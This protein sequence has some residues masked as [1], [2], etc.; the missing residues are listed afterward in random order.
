MTDGMPKRGAE[1][2]VNT[3][4]DSDA[5]IIGG[6]CAGLS[7]AR[8]AQ[9]LPHQRVAIIEGKAKR[10][11]HAWGVFASDSLKEIAADAL[12]M[13]RKTWHRWQII[14]AEGTATQTSQTRP[15]ACLE[16]KAWLTYCRQQARENGVRFIHDQVISADAHSI[17]T[18]TET[19]TTDQVYDSRPN[20]IPQG[21]MIQHFIGHEIQVVSP[22]FDPD[23]AILMDFR[24]DQSRGIHFIYVLPFSATQ[25][26]VES[27]VFS[28]QIEDN[29]FY[30][31]AIAAYLKDQFNITE[32]IVLRREQGAIPMGIIPEDH[33]TG[34][35]IGGRG[36]AIRPS[37][38][39]AF[40]FIQRQLTSLIDNLATGN[41]PTR[42]TPHHK[43]DLLMD[44]IFLKV[45]HRKPKL[46]PRLF[47]AIAQK[48]TGDEMA[49]FMA[50][51][52]DLALR[53]KVIMAMPKWPFI[54]AL[55]SGID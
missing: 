11:D 22:V 13:T 15:Y 44:R 14:T 20:P 30:E 19:I 16:S 49:R 40:A 55:I 37:S 24:C 42:M 35:P 5:V 46:A 51:E 9:S 6:G 25:A 43:I 26:L 52:A 2:P 28:P 7:L 36:G 1:N 17:T 39:Y 32:K 45:L 54:W 38:G 31:T 48:L 3:Q 50:G 4:H 18:S 47:H 29:D 33:R 10:Q 21:M 41:L 8:H 53:L 34:L 12:A 23:T 27:T